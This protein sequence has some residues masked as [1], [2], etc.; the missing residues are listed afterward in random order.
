MS[1]SNKFLT[2]ML[3]AAA[4]GA[5]AAVFIAS[6]TGQA[7]KDKVT[8]FVKDYQNNPDAKHGEWVE[9][10]T[11]LKK[12]AVEKYSDVKYKFE[13]GELKP[14]DIVTTV[15]EKAED[16]VDKLKNPPVDEEVL[17]A[18]KDVTPDDEEIT[19]DIEDIAVAEASEAT[20]IL[21]AEDALDIEND[22]KKTREDDAS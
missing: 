19:I 17:N 6:K 12:T 8:K 2:T 21:D 22:T 15:K 7:V 18:A 14:E 13:T 11:D 9:K 1:K 16:L 20:E 10:A 4:G 5:A 3:L